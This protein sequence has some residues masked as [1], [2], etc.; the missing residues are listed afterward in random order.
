[1]LDQSVQSPCRAR[2][3]RDVAC[4]CMAIEACCGHSW[5]SEA[6]PLWGVPPLL[7]TRSPVPL[8]STVIELRQTRP[9]CRFRVGD[10]MA[11]VEKPAPTPEVL[12]S[13]LVTGCLVALTVNTP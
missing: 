13:A 12:T 5:V 6:S 8:V 9:K 7:K 1:M 4:Q 11:P 10:T 3:S 2:P